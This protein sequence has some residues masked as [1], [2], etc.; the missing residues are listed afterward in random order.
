MSSWENKPDASVFCLAI[1]SL[2][3]MSQEDHEHDLP[4][5]IHNDGEGICI[6]LNFTPLLPPKKPGETQQKNTKAKS[7]TY[8]FY[9]NENLDL[10][11]LLEAVMLAIRALRPVGLPYKVV[12]SNLRTNAF[13][14]AYTIHATQFK[15]I[16]I[17]MVKDW[18]TLVKQIAVKG[19]AILHLRENVQMCDASS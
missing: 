17:T 10:C 13:K 8:T 14:I 6:A 7:S 5:S 2:T 12:S 15:N 9:I 18:E 16:S 19:N 3:I 4:E 11:D 1:L